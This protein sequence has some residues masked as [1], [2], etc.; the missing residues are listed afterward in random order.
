MVER[1]C[2]DSGNTVRKVVIKRLSG[3]FKDHWM[4]K[5]RKIRRLALWLECNAYAWAWVRSTSVM[6]NYSDLLLT[7]DTS[8][9]DHQNHDNSKRARN[10]SFIWKVMRQTEI[11]VS[12]RQR[13]AEDQ[14]Y[15]H[16][17]KLSLSYSIFLQGS[18]LNC[19]R[20]CLSVF[21]L[22]KEKSINKCNHKT[23][24]DTLACRGRA[25]W[26]VKLIM[27]IRGVI[28]ADQA[29]YSL[30][31]LGCMCSSYCNP[32]TEQDLSLYGFQG[33]IFCS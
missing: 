15:G 17:A 27:C 21:L 30:I 1:V 4:M 31:S 11:T 26:N 29:I 16:H 9:M 6:D 25:F 22:M 2:D 24:Q 3:S 28:F 18:I 32:F 5:F 8:M 10:I 7:G 20:W 12:T 33:L 14:K 19:K 13:P 23:A